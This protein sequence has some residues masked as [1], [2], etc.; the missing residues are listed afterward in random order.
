M[1]LKHLVYAAAVVLAAA[2]NEKRA[3][4]TKTRRNL[5]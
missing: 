3:E 2:C 5:E 4:E 1:K